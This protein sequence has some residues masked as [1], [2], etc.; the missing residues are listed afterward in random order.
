MKLRLRADCITIHI[1]ENSS[2]YLHVSHVLTH[3]LGRSFW[4]NETLINFVTPHTSEK[5]QAFLASL[6][7]SCAFISKTHNASFLEKLLLA[8][9]KPI[10]LV[11]KRLI[12]PFKEIPIDPY[13]LLNAKKTE[14][15]ASIR[16][17]YL[18]LAKMFHPDT[19]THEDATTV[20]ASTTKFQQI[21]EAYE[22][23]KAEKTKKIAA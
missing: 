14:S 4:V 7:Y 16:K 17:K 10:R 9:Q 19:I 12:R 23:I 11:K 6:Y 2:H 22:S 13:S 3:I 20:K 15:L 21:H 5:R 8:S 18:T 1:A